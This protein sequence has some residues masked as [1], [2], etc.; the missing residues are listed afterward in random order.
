MSF[1]T[2]DVR[3]VL[4][5]VDDTLY[6]EMTFVRSGFDAVARYLQQ[7]FG[8]SADPLVDEMLTLLAERGRGAIFDELL[9]RR[10]KY[11]AALVRELVSVYQ[12]HEPNIQLFADVP[13]VLEQLRRRKFKLGLV[14]DGHH[15][16]QMR[17]IEALG[18]LDLVDV[19]IRTD[20]LGSQFWKPHVKPF[21]VA[22]EQL[23]LAPQQA[24]YVGNDVA[25]DFQGPRRL[26]M[27]AVHIERY[28]D[29]FGRCAGCLAHWHGRDLY[30]VVD[31][32]L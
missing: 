25:R 9:R 12:K 13:P 24:M 14:T 8:W 16:V 10:G 30:A 20:E 19:A 2:A 28:V 27:G 5:D 22:L 11:D 29:R 26:G 32:L 18:L 17:K 1:S 23:G 7:R 3:G 6:D 31:L 15:Q 21:E 4:F